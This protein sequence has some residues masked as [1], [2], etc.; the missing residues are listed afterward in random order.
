MTPQVRTAV[1]VRHRVQPIARWLVLATAL[2]ILYGSLFPF[3]FAALGEHGFAALLTSLRFQPTSRGD[4]VANLLLYIPFGLCLVL[5]WPAQW[6]RLT[7]LI[8][9]LI[10][11]TLLSLAVELLQVY[12]PARVSSLT[13]VIINAVGTLA[14][15]LIALVYL[16]LGTTLR[17]PGVVSGRPDPVPLG[18]LLL[19]LA[20]RLAPFVPTIDWQKYKDAIKPLLDPEFAVLDTFRYLVGW[21][22]VGYTV[23]Q[24]W[25]REY[26]LFALFVIVLIVL[27]GRVMVVGK[28]LVPSE[29]LAL[30]V[31]MPLAA[32]F[33]SIPDR[34]RATLLIVLLA[35][36]IILQGL[37]PFQV[38]AEPQSF[39]WVPFKNSLSDSLEVNYSVLLEKCFWYFSLVWLLTRRGLGAAG[40][41]FVTAALLAAIEVAQLWLPGRSA[42][43]TDPLLAVIAGVLLAILGVHSDNTIRL[44][45]HR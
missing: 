43:I 44:P 4:L 2:L 24:L 27:A 41:A 35:A 7:A 38:V 31:C 9:T 39:S 14:G 25:R 18:V 21:L 37:K 45:S 17:I 12:A 32:L 10:V 5:A 26:A 22:V 13:D 1:A 6:R 19:W 15:G 42:E 40:A 36:T 30:L 34:Q 20:F 11:G 33:V 16:E 29:M 28:V 3:Q 23:R 8:A